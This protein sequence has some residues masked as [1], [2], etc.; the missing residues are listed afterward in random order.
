MGLLSGTRMVYVR[1]SFF[2]A[3]EALVGMKPEKKASVLLGIT[4]WMGMQ[5]LSKVDWTTEWF[6]GWNWNW[7]ISPAFATTLLG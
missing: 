7:T 4:F 3:K 2:A 1:T 6:F 5:G